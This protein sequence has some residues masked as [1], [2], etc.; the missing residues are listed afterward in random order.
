VFYVGSAGNHL[1]WDALNMGTATNTQTD[2]GGIVFA[3]PAANATTRGMDVVVK[4]TGGVIY[5]KAYAMGGFGGWTKFHD[6]TIG[7]GASLASDNAGNLFLTVSGTD[8]HLYMAWS[9]DDG[10]T[11][12]TNY[13]QGLVPLNTRAL[14]GKT[15]R[16]SAVRAINLNKDIR[17][18]RNPCSRWRWQDLG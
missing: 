16:G 10:V 6:G 11:W 13:Q 9:Y 5:Q 2:L 3:T 7:L 18:G 12:V 17:P 8:S 1:M 14:L 15:R 4:G